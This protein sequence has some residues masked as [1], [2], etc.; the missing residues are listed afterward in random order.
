LFSGDFSLKSP[1]R[2]KNRPHL[3]ADYSERLF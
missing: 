2:Y 1:E 3:Y